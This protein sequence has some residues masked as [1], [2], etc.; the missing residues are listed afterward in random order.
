MEVHF[1]GVPISWYSDISCV[2]SL[3]GKLMIWA[4]RGWNIYVGVAASRWGGR[5]QVFQVRFRLGG[6]LHLE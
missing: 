4:L 3:L 1:Y 2:V 6:M 5:Q